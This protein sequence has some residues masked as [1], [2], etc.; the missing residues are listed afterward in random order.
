[1]TPLAYALW[2][3]FGAILVWV[4]GGIVLR[5]GGLLFFFG[6]GLSMARDPHGGALL[7]LALGVLCWSLGHWHYAFRHHGYK[8][9]LACYVFCRWAPAWADPT[10]QWA[11]ATE[12]QSHG[13]ED[14]GETP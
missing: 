14:D 4:F 1:M 2:I 9:P 5:L 13:T 6:G 3:I 10:R 11:V 8:S 12:S 7:G